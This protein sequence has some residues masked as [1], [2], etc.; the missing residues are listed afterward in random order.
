MTEA[1]GVIDMQPQMK[2][3]THVQ[4]IGNVKKKTNKKS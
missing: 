4:R 2:S 1:L 3:W